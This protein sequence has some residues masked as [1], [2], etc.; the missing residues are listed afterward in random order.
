MTDQN[1]PER[2]QGVE[3]AVRESGSRWDRDGLYKMKAE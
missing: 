1:E 2:T 3:F